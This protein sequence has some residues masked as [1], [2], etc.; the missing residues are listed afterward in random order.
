MPIPLSMDY[1]V[2]D[3]SMSCVEGKV[4]HRT[5]FE[6]S[7]LAGYQEETVELLL[8]C[9]HSRARAYFFDSIGE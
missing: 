6:S 1:G 8:Q 9:G 2:T 7:A 5:L 4:A 3:I